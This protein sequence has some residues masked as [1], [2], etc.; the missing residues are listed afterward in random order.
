VLLGG[1][2]NTVNA[3]GC[4][5]TPGRKS[6]VPPILLHKHYDASSAFTLESLLREARRQK[7][8][9]TAAIPEICVLDPDGDIVRNFRAAG[10][11]NRH[12]G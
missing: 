1:Y 2:L 6:K 11:A 9:A 3:E 8:L 12:P 5:I 7:D 10:R 4:Q